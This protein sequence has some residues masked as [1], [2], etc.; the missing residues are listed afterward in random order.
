ML[1]L[2]LPPHELWEPWSGHPPGDTEDREYPYRVLSERGFPYRRID[3]NPA[4]WNPLAKAHPLLR[5]IDP[6]RA[7]RVLLCQ[8]KATVAICNFESSAL[9]LL[10]LR[11]LFMARLKIIVYDVG[12]V[13]EWKLRRWILDLAV[14]RADALLPL[15]ANQA[16]RI[17]ARWN[18]KGL[19]QPVP[20][21]I[22]CRFYTATADCPTGPVLAIGDD[23]SRDY[24]TLLTAA[25]TLA[26]P[27]VIRTRLLQQNEVTQ[28]NVQILSTFVTQV[29]YRD[30][31][32]SASI[33]VLPLHPSQHAGGVTAL[34]QA[35]AS[36]KAVIVSASE[37]IA[38]YVDHE[39]TCLVVPC[40]DPLALRQAIE[41]LLSDDGLRI[42]LGQAARAYMLA[43][44]SLDAEADLLQSVIQRLTAA[45]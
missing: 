31:I 11:R 15:G 40:H 32:A 36:G 35:M 20:M 13:G 17:V 12:V 2:V 4:P 5:A 6:I 45:G 19:V 39:R 21:C 25:E 10:L 41:R 43:H 27:V 22:D 30:L 16:A 34:V 28:T 23:I 8:R 1:I 9:L 18:P 14:P 26:A 42:A 3:L 37:G 33:I 38:D 7:L 29:E 44:C 24:E